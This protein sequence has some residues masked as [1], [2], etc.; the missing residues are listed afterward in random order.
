MQPSKQQT[1]TQKPGNAAW[2]RRGLQAGV[3]IALGYF[4]VSFTLGIAAK[5]IGLSVL[6]SA[7]MSLTMLAS[8][9][10]FAALT[11]IGADSGFLVMIITTIVVNMRYVLM[12]AAL[13]QKIDSRTGILH[14]LGLSYCVT[15]EIFGVSVSAEGKLNPFYS[16]GMAAIAAPGWTLGTALGAAVGAVLPVAAVNAMSVA[17]YGMFLAVIIPPARKNMVIAG[18]VMLSMAVSGLFSILPHLRTL[19]S[20]TRIIV[21]TLGIAAAAAVLFPIPEETQEGDGEA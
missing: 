14:R 19:S 4:A 20:G 16:Y 1:V 11:V 10:E 6:Q 12:S 3:P 13:S 7:V 21:L 18:V 8:A 15:D 2:F 17:L 5:K 9:G